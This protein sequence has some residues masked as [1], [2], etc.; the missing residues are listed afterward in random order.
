[1]QVQ[2]ETE[3]PVLSAVLTPL[4]FHDSEEHR[5]FF[6]EH[7]KVKGREAAEAAFAII[8]V[9]QGLAQAA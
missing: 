9:S 8:G 1:M 5:L 2:L 3:V 7:F 4:H 6:L